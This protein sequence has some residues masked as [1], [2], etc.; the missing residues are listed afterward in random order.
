MNLDGM[1]LD[2]SFGGSDG[3]EQNPF[4]HAS[5]GVDDFQGDPA[6][7]PGALNPDPLPPLLEDPI[8]P[9]PE[10]EPINPLPLA[11]GHFLQARQKPIPDALRWTNISHTLQRPLEFV[12]LDPVTAADQAALH[13]ASSIFSNNPHLARFI[14]SSTVNATLAQGDLHNLDA[15]QKPIGQLKDGFWGSLPEGA[16]AGMISQETGHIGMRMLQRSLGRMGGLEAFVG[17]SPAEQQDLQRLQVIQSRLEDKY[18]GL[19]KVGHGLG[20][21]AASLFDSVGSDV[22]T[23]S[24]LLGGATGGALGAVAGPEA[25]PPGALAGAAT[26]WGYGTALDMALVATGNAYVKLGMVR[27]QNGN[28]LSEESRILGALAE[29]GLNFFLD[30]RLGHSLIK[31]TRAALEKLLGDAVQQAV[32]K[33]TVQRA[34][35]H[36]AARVGKG[37]LDFAFINAGM[38]GAGI[39]GEELAMAISPG[40]F[41][42]AFNSDKILE[43]YVPRLGE[44]WVDG[45]VMGSILHIPPSGLHLGAD[46]MHASR[47]KSDFNA[48]QS[49]DQAASQSS[50]RAGAPDRYAAFLKGQLDGGPAENL[51]IPADKVMT[52]Y[53]NQAQRPGV[54]DRIFGFVPDMARQ[55]EQAL[56]TGGDVVIPYGDFVAHLGGSDVARALMPDLRVRAD[57][58]SARQAVEFE[59]TFHQRLAEESSAL[60][61]QLADQQTAA[62]PMQQVSQDLRARLVSAGVPER[63]AEA[64]SQLAAA[65]YAT[66]AERLEGQAGNAWDLYQSQGLDVRRGVEVGADGLHQDGQDTGPFGPALTAFRHDDKGAISKLMEMQTGEAVAALHHPEVGDIDLVWGKPG[67]PTVDFKNGYGLAHILA[68]HP[69]VASD[70]QSVIS[71]LTVKSKTR[72]RVILEN[73]THKGLVRLQWDGVDKRWLLTAYEKETGLNDGNTR[74]GAVAQGAEARPAIVSPENIIEQTIQEFHQNQPNASNS[75][76]GRVLMSEGHNVIE[77]FSKADTSTVVHELSHVWMTE[78]ITDAT[79]PHATEGLRGDLSALLREFGIQDHADIKTEH[80]EQ[81]A[82]AFERYLMEGHAPTAGLA[83]LFHQFKAWMTRIYQ[84]VKSLDVPMSDDMRGVF[85][86]LLATDAE[87][88]QSLRE[89]RLDPLFTDAKEAGMTDAEYAAYAQGFQRAQEKTVSDLLPKVM[90]TVR[91][92]RTSEWRAELAK[93]RE[94]IE[95]ELRAKPEWR[96]LYFLRTGKLHGHPDFKPGEG[97]THRLDKAELEAIIGA[98]GLK[99]LP[100]GIYTSKGGMALDEV[101]GLFDFSTGEAM[102]RALR[103]LEEGLRIERQESGKPLAGF[104]D[105]VRHQAKQEAR[106]TLEERHGDL[107]AT[108]AIRQEALNRIHND[109]QSAAMATELSYLARRA[110]HN[111]GPTE[112]NRMRDWV[113]NQLDGMPIRRGADPIGFMRAESNSG[114]QAQVALTKGDFDKAYA[115]R[116]QQLINHLF[117][118]ESI[119]ARKDFEM[120]VATFQRLA[121]KRQLPNMD[122]PYLNQIHALLARFGFTIRDRQQAQE[123]GR[124][125][126]GISL[127][128]F[129]EEKHAEGQEIPYPD[130]LEGI[131]TPAQTLTVAQFREL[132]RTIDSL[133]W[134]GRNAKR[135][136]IEGKYRTLHDLVQMAVEQAD[137]MPQRELS[138]YLNPQEVKGW[139]GFSEKAGSGAR[140]LDATLLKQEQMFNWLDHDNPLGVYNLFFKSIKEAQHK[141]DDM[142]LKYAQEFRDLGERIE[143]EHAIWSRA[144]LESRER[145]P[146]LPMIM[147]KE[148]RPVPSQSMSR[149]EIIMIALNTGNASNFRK[150]CTGEGWNPLAVRQMLDRLMT[151]GDWEFVQGVW[152]ILESMWPAIEA[153][154]L[155]LTGIAPDKVAVTPFMTPFGEYRGGYFPV[156]YD[157]ARGRLAAQ[158]AEKSTHGIYEKSY[159]RARTAHGHT[160]TRLEEYSAPL[161]LSFNF[162]PFK[163]RQVVHDLTHREVLN[164]ADKFFSHPT[165]YA[166]IER[167]LGQEYAATPKKW[168]QHIAN[169]ANVD[170]RGL[171]VW[172]R[173][174]SSVRTKAVVALIGYRISTMLKHGGTALFNSMGEIGPIW[175]MRASGEFFGTPEHM[176]RMRDFIFE[177]SGEMRHRMNQYDRDVR[178]QLLE[179]M[180]KGGILHDFERF[181][182]YG[183]AM[184]DFAS[185]MPTWLGA[186]RKALSEGKH[187]REAIW[188]ADKTV[189]N[190]HGAQGAADLAAVQRGGEWMKAITMF[191]GFFNHIYNRQRNITRIAR[192]GGRH[193]REGEFAEAGSDFA[194]VA[195]RSVFYLIIPAVFEAIVGHGAP[196]EDEGET[197]GEWFA[198]AIMGEIPAGIPI[199]RDLAKAFVHGRDF[200]ATPLV[201]VAKTVMRTIEDAAKVFSSDEDEAR[202]TWLKSAL[203]STGY[204]FGLPTGQL[205]T[206]TQFLWDYAN[207]LEDPHG[208]DE[209]FRGLAFGTHTDKMH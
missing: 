15:V 167:T 38:A 76:R 22:A 168:L 110:T 41:E 97:A 36:A 120:G 77:L 114:R 91:K 165:V 8:P 145:T 195:A 164:D 59:Q 32:A 138:G 207:D 182:H 46:W 106:A 144:W 148:G 181:G 5:L 55:L 190:A 156:M 166:A 119:G 107:F 116:K 7:T 142:L 100:H 48:L 101:A 1:N 84:S 12:A 127:R 158:R 81:F 64:M 129:M 136:K 57:G 193:L 128:E 34:L 123:E 137:K 79:G 26:G 2:D 17:I 21:M 24:M 150:L 108:N 189:R 109:A 151:K 134:N 169:H 133:A 140:A 102:A 4:D 28:P 113:R 80:H 42:T 62:E 66:R 149:G 199:A 78:L 16:D 68:K 53:Q 51:F 52:L 43:E 202:R 13:E 184:L 161:D 196:H 194:M 93:E 9:Q 186:Y 27:D 82:R 3:F 203:E 131:S 23:K 157:P 175:F 35:G 10:Q 188:I 139:T 88:G 201:H 111:P 39:I 160:Y 33:P 206:S 20:A 103:Q 180:G 74:T 153:M 50:L 11:I 63:K 58:M 98:E 71:G 54:N 174:V 85:D 72:N 29:G 25:I 155:R 60:K 96:A 89:Q 87:I 40:K 143:K 192:R 19:G 47:A 162:L 152:D 121:G 132:K 170:A 49:L 197:W 118:Q 95:G 191:Y 200:E 185:A 117:A 61:Q 86:R 141:E 124:L 177:R 115:F 126:N 163:I 56:P 171:E 75:S 172:E 67:D 187:E 92:Q 31:P 70:L 209:W 69:E 198:K 90:E 73:D 45:L 205:A 183:V 130:R 44:A 176:A 37:G 105:Y 65:R 146:E 112:L 147:G 14:G 122:Q 99:D 154:E 83:R 135:V 179:T 18:V 178:E 173:V 94:R 125:A 104:D 204:V 208:L 159:Q 30:V 6:W